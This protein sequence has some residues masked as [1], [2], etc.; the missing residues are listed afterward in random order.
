MSGNI[1]PNKITFAQVRASKVVNRT[2]NSWLMIYFFIP[3]SLPITV[4]FARLGVGPNRA[5]LLRAGISVIALGMMCSVNH[6]V[7]W[8]G[9]VL[10][11]FGIAMD[12]VDGSLARS[13]NLASHAG[14]SFDGILDVAIELSLI[15]VIAVHLWRLGGDPFLLVAAGVSVLAVAITRIA[16]FRSGIM[17]K[18]VYA[19]IT[20]ET[21][22]AK[23]SHP[24]LEQW[25]QRLAAPL[26]YIE[27]RG[28]LHLW[29]LRNIGLVA[30][31]LLGYPAV[32]VY[33]IAGMDVC[34]ALILVPARIAR[35][36]VESHVLRRSK[37]AA[38][39]K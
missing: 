21:A 26:K 4:L 17:D 39:A 37:S 12:F 13:L 24:T 2:G 29:D 15:F 25:M 23:I 5:T 27:G 16:A 6:G 18:N 35:G 28:Y 31:L 32:W 36:F 34:M 11:I 9:V 30:A 3:I 20:A 38:S 33:L 7:F 22:G 14:K 1:N 8:A 10:F 19:E